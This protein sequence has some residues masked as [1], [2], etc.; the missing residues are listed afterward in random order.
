MKKLYLLTI[1]ILSW[2]I[3][4]H[5][6][7]TGSHIGSR[8]SVVGNFEI[9][10]NQIAINSS[11]VD[12]WESKD[13][14]FFVYQPLCGDFSIVTR[15]DELANSGTWVK[16]GLMMRES[17]TDTSPY[18]FIATYQPDNTTGTCMQL[19]LTDG[20]TSQNSSCNANIN[21]NTWYKLAREGKTVTSYSSTDGNTWEVLDSRELEFS[22]LVYV[23]IASTSFDASQLGRAVYS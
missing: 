12:I 4:A 5:A 16:S 23:G 21:I 1:L 22:N 7:W 19:R 14:F 20:G 10:G 11:G 18:A 3:A 17:L 8:S 15:L 9:V 6:Q 2:S 13:D